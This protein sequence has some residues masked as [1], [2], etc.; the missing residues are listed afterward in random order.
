MGVPKGRARLVSP[1]IL[2]EANPQ[3]RARMRDIHTFH[4]ILEASED[5]RSLV[6]AAGTWSEVGRTPSGPNTSPSRRSEVS[7]GRSGTFHAGAK[8]GSLWQLEQTV[9]SSGSS[10]A[11]CGHTFTLG[12][13][14]AG[15]P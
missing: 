14:G 15:S 1:S 7:S 5:S 13:F 6:G 8:A 4:G 2:P 9:A 3:T 11:Q 12:T 10:S